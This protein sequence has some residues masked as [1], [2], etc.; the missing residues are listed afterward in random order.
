[1]PEGCVVDTSALQYLFRIGQ[2]DILQTLFDE[3]LVADAVE[4]ELN[5][6][7]STGY[8]VPNITDYSWIT[9]AKPE[10][11]SIPIELKSLGDGECA[12]ILLARETSADQIILDDLNARYTAET[13]GLH[14]T[15]TIGILMRA[16]EQNLIPKIAPLLEQLI[17]AGMWISI[18]IKRYALEL[19]GE[20]N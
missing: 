2:L 18:E 10:H 4:Q 6:G 13:L 20:G 16:K 9:V 7:K 15:G 11:H 3:V 12:S 5:R 14:V 8:S 19:S 1:M 17:D